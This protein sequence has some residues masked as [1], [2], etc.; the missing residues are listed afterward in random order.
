ME[1]VLENL[2]ETEKWFNVKENEY[3]NIYDNIQ[4]PPNL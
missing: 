3:Q 1:K 4:Q 2:R